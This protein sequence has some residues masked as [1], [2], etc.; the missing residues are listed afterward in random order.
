MATE[1]TETIVIADLQ[2]KTD[3]AVGRLAQLKAQQDDLKKST[4]EL[5]KEFDKNAE[6]IVLNGLKLKELSREEQVLTKVVQDNQ[7]ATKSQTGSIDQQRAQLAILTKQYNALSKEEREN[8]KAGQ[9]LQKQIKGI[10]DSLKTQEKAVGDTRRNVG[11]YKDAILEAANQLPFLGTAI[12]NVEK[13]MV[14]A[15]AS[16]TSFSGALKGG[17][18]GAI[19]LA[20]AALAS[21]FT[22]TGEGEDQLEVITARFKGAFQGLV[23]NLANGV[24][25]FS[26]AFKSGSGFTALLDGFKAF[27]ESISSPE[28][29]ANIKNTSEAYVK[30]ALALQAIE[31]AERAARVEVSKRNLEI[32]RLLLTSKD[33]SLSDQEQIDNLERVKALEIDLNNTQVG[34][35][36]QRLANAIA[37]ANTQKDQTDKVKDDVADARIKL[38]ELIGQSKLV[39]QTA[40]NRISLQRQQQEAKRLAEIEAEFAARTKSIKDASTQ[41][42]L[43]AQLAFNEK[44]I[45]TVEAEKLVTEAKLK[46]LKRQ[47]S[48]EEVYGKSNVDTRKAILET[49]HKLEQDAINERIRLEQVKFAALSELGNSLVDLNRILGG[50]NADATDFGKTLASVQI[51]I[52]AATT[53]GNAIS[54]AKGVTGFDYILQISIASAAALSAI[55]QVKALFDSVPETPRPEFYEGGYT[56]DGPPKQESKALGEKP[57]T[58]HRGE[59]IASNAALRTPEGALAGDILMRIMGKQPRFN[60][61]GYFNGGT[62]DGGMSQRIASRPVLDSQN[63]Q[64]QII[65]AVRNLPPAQ[66][67]VRDIVKKTAEVLYVNVTKDLK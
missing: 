65:Q 20:T 24:K 64:Q 58:Y 44:L 27:N 35:A 34:F 11:N 13:A 28:A 52:S 21:F 50:A 63:T 60:I 10:S 3:Q 1:T 15:K 19:A 59:L 17:F 43:F 40:D 29:A 48:N 7:K 67:A 56:G 30:V 6:A 32:E 5:E 37:I 66:V 31:D 62:F 22:A 45:T 47:S 2:I 53:I 61:G 57:Y 39:L 33:L 14:I 16:F 46:E 51:A 38:N 49:E 4:K 26:T 36:R 8:T 42:Q 25:A 18:A 55:A 9:A 23:Q 12:A 41:E 54:S